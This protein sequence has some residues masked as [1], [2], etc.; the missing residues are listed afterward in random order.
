VHLRNFSFFLELFLVLTQRK[1]LLKRIEKCVSAPPNTQ[2]M[3]PPTEIDIMNTLQ[4]LRKQLETLKSVSQRELQNS[5]PTRRH[6]DILV[7]LEKN[8]KNWLE[9]MN[10]QEKRRC[11]TTVE[12]IKL[13][14]L[15]GK[16][17]SQPGDR[18]VG[19]ALRAVGFTPKRD[20]TVVGRNR[21]FWQFMGDSAWI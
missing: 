16:N 7:E 13:A 6:S 18:L 10:N 14:N 4:P 19:Q 5:K 21:R 3:Q 2:E 17:G 15:R 12:I 20:W 9:S 8:L 11:F 1:S